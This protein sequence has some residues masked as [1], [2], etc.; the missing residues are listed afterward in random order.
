MEIIEAGDTPREYVEPRENKPEPIFME[1][2]DSRR[3]VL[4]QVAKQHSVDIPNFKM[5]PRNNDQKKKTNLY[6][7]NAHKKN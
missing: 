3:D 5:K 7:I 4:F 2:M 1:L 6:A